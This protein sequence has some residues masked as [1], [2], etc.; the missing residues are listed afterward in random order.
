MGAQMNIVPRLR[1]DAY[2]AAPKLRPILTGAKFTCR[3]CGE[4]IICVDH[5]R[6]CQPVYWRHRR[7]WQHRI[8]CED[9]KP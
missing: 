4:E 1:L 9:L 8:L 7:K 5:G 2:T 6:P 3:T